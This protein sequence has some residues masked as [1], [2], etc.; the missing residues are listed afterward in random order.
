[1][2]RLAARRTVM[3]HAEAESKSTTARIVVQAKG[4]TVTPAMKDYAMEKVSLAV[5]NFQAD[6]K[7]VDV[8]MSG[9]RRGGGSAGWYT[10]W[11]LSCPEMQPRSRL[12]L[13]LSCSA[14]QAARPAGPH[15]AHS[16]ARRLH[17]SQRDSACG[18]HAGPSTLPSRS[19]ASGTPRA[20]QDVPRDAGA[21]PAR[22]TFTPRRMPAPPSQQAQNHTGHPH[23]A[24]DDVCGA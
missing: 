14:E 7:E 17:P 16:R 15:R 20:W 2:V 21:A 22:R 12:G 6:V 24:G 18:G 13:S 19:R 11:R 9:E 23:D 5:H 10:T 8:H 1:M 3:T 4:T